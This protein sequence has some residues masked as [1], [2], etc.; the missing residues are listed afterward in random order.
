L[1]IVHPGV[2]GRNTPSTSPKLTGSLYLRTHGCTH[3]IVCRLLD[4]PGGLHFS[5]VNVGF[6]DNEAES[7]TDLVAACSDTLESLTLLYYPTGAFPSASVTDQ[8]LI[9]ARGRRHT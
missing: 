1:D 2:H 7:M 8:Y 4:L 3:H 9:A 6:F 5:K